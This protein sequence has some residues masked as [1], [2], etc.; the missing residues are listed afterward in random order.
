MAKT[1]VIPITIMA[2]IPL[3][4]GRNMKI[5]TIHRNPPMLMD[6]AMD[7]VSATVSDLKKAIMMKPLMMMKIMKNIMIQK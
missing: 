6:I 4:H 5:M 1:M 3:I 7:T 2:Q